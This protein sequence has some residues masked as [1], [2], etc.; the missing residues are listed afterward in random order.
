MDWLRLNDWSWARIDVY[1]WFTCALSKIILMFMCEYKC[2]QSLC[3]S[4]YLKINFQR[5]VIYFARA[6][7]Y[8]NPC[9]LALLIIGC[10]LLSWLRC[11]WDMYSQIST[12][13]WDIDWFMSYLDLSN[14][15]WLMQSW[16]GL[17]C[18]SC[19]YPPCGSP[20]PLG[21]RKDHPW[22][23]NLASEFLRSVKFA[24]IGCIWDTSWSDLVV[25]RWIL[26]NIG[27]ASFGF[28]SIAAF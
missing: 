23:L 17:G 22:S 26:L 11:L 27:A 7:G 25:G 13:N 21:G 5:L 14:P 2:S 6:H 18:I 1:A 3:R 16:C 24:F 28:S 20:S 19:L 15:W 4:K 12:N 9:C 10:I 8:L